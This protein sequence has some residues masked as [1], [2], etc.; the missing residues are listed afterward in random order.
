MN[1]FISKQDFLTHMYE[2]TIDEISENDDDLLTDAIAT[3][4]AQAEGYLS[5]YDTELIFASGNGVKYAALRTY[6]KD[7]TKWH[8]INICNVSVD[9][10]IAEKRYKFAISELEK[11]QKGATTP[12]GWAMLTEP[13]TIN[14]PFLVTSRPKRNNYI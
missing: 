6:I 10:E 7:L 14:D 11:I 1:D 9:L 2:G 3:A 4:M 5:R 12:K 8:F 13:D